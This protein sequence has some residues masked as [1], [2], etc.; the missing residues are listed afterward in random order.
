MTTRYS[1]KDKRDLSVALIKA[2]QEPAEGI[3]QKVALEFCGRQA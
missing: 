1:A 3:L 2:I